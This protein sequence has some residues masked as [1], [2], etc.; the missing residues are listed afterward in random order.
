MCNVC[1]AILFYDRGLNV[2]LFPVMSHHSNLNLFILEESR[3]LCEFD[4]SFIFM[5]MRENL[6]FIYF[7]TIHMYRGTIIW[8]RLYCL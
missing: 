5:C 1:N 3:L 7:F 6:K 2:G 8:R 4:D